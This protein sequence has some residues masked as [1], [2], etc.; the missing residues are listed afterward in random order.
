MS[1]VAA[2]GSSGGLVLSWC[3]GVDLECFASDKNN[4]SA[5]CYSDTPPHSPWILSCVYGSPNKRDRRAFWDTFAS[6]GEGFEASWLCIGDF[7]SVLDQTEKIGG[8]P[9]YSSSHYPFRSFI[10]HF[11]IIDVGFVGNPF[12]WVNNK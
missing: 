10:D 1:Q 4:I 3:P 11:G 2:S 12:T 6:I 7:N 9:V 5:W 8:R